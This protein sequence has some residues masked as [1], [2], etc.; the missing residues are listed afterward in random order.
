MIRLFAMRH[1]PTAW[2]AEGRLQGHRDEP[3]SAAGRASAAAWR[4]PAA[5]REAPLFASPLSRAVETARLTFGRDPAKDDRLREASWGAWEGRK[6][7]EIENGGGAEVADALAGGLEFAPPGGESP[8]E[9]IARLTPFFRERAD[10]G[11]DIA[12]VVHAGVLRAMIAM[13]TGWDHCGRPPHRPRD[14]TGHIYRVADGGE[15]TLETANV[16]LEPTP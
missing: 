4:A 10:D 8:R 6:W 5:F 9:V 14:A 2:N 11:H 16:P 15:L 7:A 1:A 12:I 13:A 3:L